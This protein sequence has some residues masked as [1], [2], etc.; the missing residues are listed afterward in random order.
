[1]FKKS[2]LD[3][4]IEERRS[5]RFIKSLIGKQSSAL[6]SIFQSCGVHVAVF[7][8][9]TGSAVGLFFRSALCGLNSSSTLL[10]ALYSLTVSLPH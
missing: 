1:M 9:N 6:K 7:V 5:L 4:Y 3:I 8:P 2:G 10:L